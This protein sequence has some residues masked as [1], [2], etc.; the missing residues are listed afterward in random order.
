MNHKKS[1]KEKVNSDVYNVLYTSK[2]VP[3]TS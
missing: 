1:K 3:D 2:K